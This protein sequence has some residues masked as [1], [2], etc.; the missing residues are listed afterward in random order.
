MNSMHDGTIADGDSFLASFL[1]QI[2]GSPAFAN[3]VV[4][5][6][7]DEGTS[8]NG[9]GGHIVTIAIASGRTPDFSSGITYQ[10]YSI[11]RT[12]EEAWRLP[13]LGGASSAPAIGF[14][15]APGSAGTAQVQ[16]NVT[17]QSNSTPVPSATPAPSPTAQP[18][19]AASASWPPG[20]STSR[21]ELLTPCPD[22]ANCYLYTVRSAVANGSPVNDDVP[23]IARYFGVSVQA[24][25]AM[26]PSAVL[27]VHPGELL[28]I[29]PPTR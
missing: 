28:R 7:F 9:G 18:S 22:A 14:S 10:H 4:F 5:I 12:I 16:P 20:A 13:L 6:T 2:I 25:Y 21:M 23:S 19:A 27:G 15:A 26:N 17:L 29:P 11:L 8:G 3:S 1:P 24:V